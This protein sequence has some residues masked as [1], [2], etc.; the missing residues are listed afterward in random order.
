MKK[1][2]LLLISNIL[3]ANNTMDLGTSTLFVLASIL[4]V[5]LVF[6]T[7]MTTKKIKNKNIKVFNI[8]TKEDIAQNS[9]EKTLLYFDLQ[10]I[11]LYFFKTLNYE[12]S[13]NNNIF[14]VKQ[15]MFYYD[16]S[17][18]KDPKRHFYGD[19]TN[20]I[21]VIFEA[22]N[23]INQKVKNE[24]IIIELSLKNLTD[25]KTMLFIDISISGEYDNEEQIFNEIK[26]STSLAM[27]KQREELTLALQEAK[28]SLVYKDT[29][30]KEK[31][32]ICIS[33]P[34][35]NSENQ[36]FFNVTLK[37]PLKALIIHENSIVS[38]VISK[39]LREFNV[40]CICNRS[41][42]G[43]LDKIKDGVKCA[44]RIILI[45]SNLFCNFAD[46]DIN[47][48]IKLQNEY[49]FKII[50]IQNNYQ[51]TSIIEKNSQDLEF[52]P[53]PYTID[54]IRSIVNLAKIQQE[55]LLNK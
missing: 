41:S 31:Y 36:N 34:L 49:C 10:E 6:Y 43:L 52:L 35:L 12:A 2:L 1:A 51:M 8:D 9:F 39:N 16:D 17:V 42:V 44:Y 45:D 46:E 5:L 28:G 26:N 4:I 55:K 38:D 11:F 23:L 3:F 22:T 29:Q 33:I 37:T 19:Y 50:L 40:E 48:L 25:N 14:L 53:L 32:A 18:I 54:T 27:L 30:S 20:I 15:D 24:T 47:N 13:K 7:F 21:K